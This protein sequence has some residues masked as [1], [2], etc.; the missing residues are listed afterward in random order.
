[1]WWYLHF[2]ALQVEST[3]NILVSIPDFTNKDFSHL[4]RVDKHT[5]LCG[6]TTARNSL[7]CSSFDPCRRTLSSIYIPAGLLWAELSVAR[8]K[9]SALGFPCLD[10]FARLASWNTTPSGVCLWYC[11]SSATRSAYLDGLVNAR[12]L[13]HFGFRELGKPTPLKSQ[14]SSEL[15]WHP[16]LPH[17]VV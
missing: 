8:K 7:V 15:W 1:M 12:I 3:L 9:N 4:A 17:S 11:R 10:C 2:A 6:L 16:M 5:G 14:C 13:A